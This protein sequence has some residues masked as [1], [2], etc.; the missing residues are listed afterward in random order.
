MSGNLDAAGAHR[1]LLGSDGKAL[2]ARLRLGL[3]R[4]ANGAPEQ[5]VALVEEVAFA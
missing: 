3:V 1:R 2:W 4:D 5:I